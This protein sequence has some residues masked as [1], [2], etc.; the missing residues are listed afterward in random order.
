MSLLNAARAGP[1]VLAPAQFAW[2]KLVDRPLWYA[3]HSLGFETEGIGRYLHPNPRAEAVGARDHWAVEQRGRQPDRRP[4]LRS[5]DRSP[6]DGTAAH[7]RRQI[8]GF[9]RI[10]IVHLPVFPRA[11]RSAQN[12]TFD[13]Q[14]GR[15]SDL[16]RG[17]ANGAVPDRYRTVP[18]PPVHCLARRRR[19]LLKSAALAGLAFVAFLVGQNT[20][21]RRVVLMMA[22]IASVPPAGA[23][24]AS[25][26]AVPRFEQA[27][28]LRAPDAAPSPPSPLAGPAADQVPQAFTQQLQQRPTIT[29]P[30]G[31]PLPSAA[32]A[33]EPSRSGWRTD[34]WR[35]RGRSSGRRS[36]SSA[37]ARKAFATSGPFTTRLSEALRS[38]AQLCRSG[39]RGGG[40]LV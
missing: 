8:S 9:V 40:D 35:S 29:P 25:A 33:P 21:P 14:T 19:P 24:P 4:E 37:P 10:G 32:N 28:P 11:I 27:S 36:N 20:A 1:G 30:P 34:P 6:C 18:S 13:F 2:L 12:M 39:D 17:R 31:S 5:G 3:L 7:W 15:R 16:H 22:S 23:A 26:P 38:S